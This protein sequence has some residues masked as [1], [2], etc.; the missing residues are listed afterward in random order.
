MLKFSLGKKLFDFSAW[1]SRSQWSQF[2]NILTKKEKTF[3]FVFVILF[4]TSS[5][6][7]FANFYLKNTEVR[8]SEGGIF[9]E[10][11]LGQPRFINPIYVSSSDIDRDLMELLFSGIT[12]YDENGKLVYDLAKDITTENNGKTYRVFLKDDVLWQDSGS[13]SQIKKLTAD[14]IVFTIKTIQNQ[15]YKSPLRVNWL[16]VEVE[17]INDFEIIFKLKN[18]YGAFIEN[19]SFK[20]LPGHIWQKISAQ[21]F[22]LSDYNLKPVGSGPYQ[23]KSI[24]RDGS[25]RVN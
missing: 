19:L 14:D 6:Y 24:S 4:L 2:F 25:G 11:L 12:K 1:P 21:N 15:E 18:S 3:F 16:G 20:I 17:K 8:P 7:L 9:S 5:I 10:G 23:F 22:P 13:G